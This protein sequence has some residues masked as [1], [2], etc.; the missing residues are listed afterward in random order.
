MRLFSRC[1][2]LLAFVFLAACGG[3]GGSAGP[4]TPT[5]PTPT[6]T[7]SV[8]TVSVQGVVFYDEDGGGQLDGIESVRMPNLTVS[9]GGR[10]TVTTD[11]GRFSFDAPEGA[12]QAT[13]VES[14]LPIGWQV[15]ARSVTLPVNGELLLPVTVPIGRNKPNVYMAFGDS[16]TAGDGSRGGDG[17]LGWTQDLLRGYWGRASLVNE[18]VAATRSDRGNER[19][20]ASL[21]TVRPAYVLILYGTNDWN[22]SSCRD[23]FPCYTID[24]LR[25]MI[26]QVKAFGSVPVVATIPPV[27]PL[28]L[29]RDAENRNAW[30]KR[31]NDL[32]RP[33]VKQEGAALADIHAAMLKEPDLSELFFDFLH[34]NDSGY[35]II[36]RE[37]ARAITAPRGTTSTSGGL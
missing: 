34:P 15:T 1:T 3:G 23:S 2:A 12:Q 14:S 11:G 5:S 32:I 27:N 35:E 13:I 36:G 26:G 9:I 33:M 21:A 24:A 17:Y 22:S 8:R 10:T 4:T 28:L 25:S 20:G 19:L 31:M 29:D 16:I 18:G 37:F 30:V 6:P 7:P